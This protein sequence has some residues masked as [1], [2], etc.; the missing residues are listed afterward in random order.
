VGSR[1]QK[2]IIIKGADTALRSEPRRDPLDSVDLRERPATRQRVAMVLRTC[3]I[4]WHRGVNIG[5][6]RRR[7]SAEIERA[8][9]SGSAPFVEKLP[10]GTTRCC[11]SAARSFREASAS[12]SRCARSPAWRR[13]VSANDQLVI[14]RRKS[15]C[16]KASLMADRTSIV[17]AHRL[18]TIQDVDRIHVLHRGRIVETGSHDELLARRGAYWRLYQL[19]FERS[20]EPALAT[21]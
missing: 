14:P 21:A 13:L 11:A 3:S 9:R 7:D 19:Q 10:N 1:A 2:D 20:E 5:P 4:Q 18:S 12:C 8:A 15:W 16:S 17:I 6:E